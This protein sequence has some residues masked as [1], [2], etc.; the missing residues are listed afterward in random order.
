L[1]RMNETQLKTESGEELFEPQIKA[2]DRKIDH[3]VYKLYSLADE[4]VKIMEYSRFK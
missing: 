3:L 4:K 1:K 2:T